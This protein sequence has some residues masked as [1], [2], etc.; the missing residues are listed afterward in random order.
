MKA[1]GRFVLA[2]AP[3]EDADAVASFPKTVYRFY[4]IEETKR[5]LSEVGFRDIAMVREPIGSKDTVFAV[6]RC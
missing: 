1:D 5:L 4:S 2:F 3:K 6:S